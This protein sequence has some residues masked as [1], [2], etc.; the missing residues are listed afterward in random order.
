LLLAGA[1]EGDLTKRADLY[2]R[3]QKR[4]IDQVYLIPI[5]I[6]RY[7]VAAAANV[8]GIALD[9]HGFPNYHGASLV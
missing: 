4:V 2:V 5:Y 8:K 9:A 6:L 7:N 3:A 1:T